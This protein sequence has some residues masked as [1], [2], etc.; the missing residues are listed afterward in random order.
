LLDEIPDCEQWVRYW[1]L[2]TSPDSRA[3]YTVGALLGRHHSGELIIADIV[4]GQ[5][6]WPEVEEMIVSTALDD[7]P[8]VSIGVEQVAYQLAA[9]QSLQR[10]GELL[11]Y[12]LE[13]HRP[14]KGKYQR[15]MP[16]ASKAKAGTLKVAR[17]HWTPGFIGELM[18]FTGSQSSK[19]KD[20]QVDAISG[21]VDLLAT[22]GLGVY[23]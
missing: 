15:A 3:D 23:V 4:R 10:R 21:A 14:D 13:G 7:G 12:T 19:A 5:W 16:W 22:A 9:V 2:A 18:G 11:G 20:D 1:D 17:R 8:D 6:E